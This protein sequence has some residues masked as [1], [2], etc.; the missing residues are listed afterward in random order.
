MGGYVI[1]GTLAAFGCLCVLWT[2]LGVFL[3]DLRG[4]TLV[5]W[6]NAPE[7]AL[8]RP[9]WLR[10]LG[11]LDCPMLIVSE[12]AEEREDAEICSPEML[13]SRLTE[14]RNRGNG[15]GNGDHSGRHQR[16]GISE[17]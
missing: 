10:S 5:Y 4:W 13:L 3:P 6:G 2:I 8:W 7:E 16:R 17:L 9:R 15:T 12:S 11:L 14:E 1:L